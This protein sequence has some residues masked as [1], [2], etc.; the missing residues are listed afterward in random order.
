MKGRSPALIQLRN[1]YLI[2]RYYYWHELNQIRRDITL[3]RLS[4]EEVFLEI[5]TIESILR[6][7]YHLWKEIKAKKPTEK[8]L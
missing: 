2:K 3:V 4:R 8:Q 6:D 5:F 7:C 1:E